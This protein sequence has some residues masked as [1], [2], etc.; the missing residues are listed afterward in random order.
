MM[1]DRSLIDVSHISRSGS[2]LRI[3]LPKRVAEI[4]GFGPSDIV[5]FINENDRIIIEKLRN[6]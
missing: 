1:A 2:S 6:P 4:C 3:T 5:A